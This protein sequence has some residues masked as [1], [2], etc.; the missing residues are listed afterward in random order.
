[1]IRETANGEVICCPHCLANYKLSMAKPDYIHRFNGFDEIFYVALCFD[2]RRLVTPQ[3]KV[4]RK[5][6]VQRIGRNIFSNPDK[7]LSV[8]TEVAMIMNDYN[9][10]DALLNGHGLTRAGYDAVKQ[11]GYWKLPFAGSGLI[12]IWT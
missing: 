2:C 5:H 7:L 10:P 9:F 6:T 1:M 3:R 8:T 11:G 4:G 12:M